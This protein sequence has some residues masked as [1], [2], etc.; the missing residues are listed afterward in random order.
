MVSFQFRLS[1]HHAWTAIQHGVTGSSRDLDLRSNVELTFQGHH[2]YIP[3]R[4]D[5]GTRRLPNSVAS[6]LI[7]DVL[8]EKN[9]L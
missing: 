4:L 9:I 1:R 7:S 5:E 6:Y 2:A 3:A 8:S